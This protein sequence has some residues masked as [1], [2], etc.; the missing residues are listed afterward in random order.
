MA[1]GNRI[2]SLAR[3]KGHK[4]ETIL[5]WLRDA[6]QHAEAMEEELLARYRIQRGQLYSLWAYVGHKGE[7]KKA[8]QR[9]PKVGR[10]GAPP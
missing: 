6:A 10:S 9:A 1:E 3:V 8:T 2:S 5:D 4:E 7:K